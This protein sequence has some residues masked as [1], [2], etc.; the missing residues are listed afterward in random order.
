MK[1]AMFHFGIYKKGGWGRTF[2]LGRGLALNGCDVT[3]ITSDN[4]KGFF[5]VKDYEEGVNIIKFKD[6]ISF[7]ILNKGFGILSFFNKIIFSIFH[8]FDIVH[9]DSHRPN[10]Y[11]PCIINRFLYR[12]KFVIEWWDNFGFDGQLKN[13]SKLFKIFLSNWESRNEIAS[14]IKADG[15]IVLSTLMKERALFSG[16][17]ISKIRILHGGADVQ[18]IRY[19]DRSKNYLRNEIYN[20]YEI[21]FGYI[22]HGNN[23]INDLMCFLKAFKLASS[24]H[25]LY[26]M[27][28]GTP[29]SKYYI[30]NFGI[31]NNI[32]NCGWVDYSN[33]NSILYLPD[34]F[35][36]TKVNNN[37]NKYGWPNKIGDYMACGRA[38]MINLYGDLSDFVSTYPNGFIIVNNN[39][40]NINKAIEDISNNKYNLDEMGA[41]NRFIA[42]KYL[43]WD[44]KAQELLEYYNEIY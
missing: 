9:A 25:F 36:L 35:I 26:F 10:S 27:N 21:I 38:I 12:S 20:K 17:S 37:I 24:N 1:I 28:F 4:K 43:S 8:K 19:I 23:D 16:V 11:Y 2:P 13:K 33:I 6:I 5:P 31:N 18:S 44:K 29:F 40:E 32:V 34:I 39:P 41:Y 3:I 22:G 42:E 30:D 15:V 14:K 7:N